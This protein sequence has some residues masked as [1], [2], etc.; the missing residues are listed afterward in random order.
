[1]TP[2]ECYVEYN[3]LKRHFTSTY[4]YFK[5]RGKLNL[6]QK[7]F[8]SRGDKVFFAKVA[9]HRDPTGFIV[10]NLLINQKAWIRDIAYSEQSERVYTEWIK[11]KESMTYTFKSDLKKLD[12]DF[13]SNLKV[14]SGEHPQLIK[15]Y[16]GDEVNFETVC[17]I[18]QITGCIV[19]W[20]RK[21][22]GEP[23]IEEVCTKIKKYLPFMNTDGKKYEKI[24][25]D[26]YST[27]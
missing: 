25:V 27:V 19:Y 17:I 9:K 15:L 5:Y 18:C 3:A 4:D 12:L 6:S 26:F 7:T 13:D 21:L 2:F 23:V 20:E 10:A 1:M 8:E 16:L 24:I 11:K 22:S 14:K